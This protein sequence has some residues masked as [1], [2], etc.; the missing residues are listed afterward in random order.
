[1]SG[2][3]VQ[4]MAVET[5]IELIGPSTGLGLGVWP[6]FTLFEQMTSDFVS[7][8]M[9]PCLDCTTTTPSDS[10]GIASESTQ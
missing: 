2:A 1:M 8:T 4:S 9:N 10:Y 7:D 6:G 3:C 5:L